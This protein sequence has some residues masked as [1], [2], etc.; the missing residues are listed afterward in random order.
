[1]KRLVVLLLLTSCVSFS[2]GQ[3]YYTGVGPRFGKFNTG[4]SFKHFYAPA[5]R[6]GIEID[7][8]YTN[9]PQGGYTLKGFYLIQNRIKVPIV[10]I[11]LDFIYGGGLHAAY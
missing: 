2:Y 4:L 9:I 5:N 7:A 11:P 10:Q 3:K 6:Y 1:M 8:Y